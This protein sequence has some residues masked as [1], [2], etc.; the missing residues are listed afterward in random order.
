MIREKAQA[1][2]RTNA[3]LAAMRQ[4]LGKASGVIRIGTVKTLDLATIKAKEFVDAIL[5][6]REGDDGK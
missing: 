5:S 6:A 1:V 4:R 3:M 2:E